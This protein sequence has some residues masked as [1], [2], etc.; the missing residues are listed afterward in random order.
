VECSSDLPSNLNKTSAEEGTMR[1]LW[2][3][4]KMGS[5]LRPLLIATFVLTFVHLDEWLWI[6]YSTQVF[7]NVG[8]SQNAAMRAS[9]FMSLPQAIVSVL[10]LFCF[11][12]FSRRCLLIVPT[13]VSIICAVLA[14]FGLLSN[15]GELFGTWQMHNVMPILASID[16]ASAAAASESAYTVVPELFSQRDRILGS[17]IVGIA[18]NTFGGIVA[19]ISLSVVNIHGTHFVLL[20]FIVM[21]VIYVFVVYAYL[22]ETNGYSFKSI[23]QN[24]SDDIPS[25]LHHFHFPSFRYILK[26]LWHIPLPVPYRG[27]GVTKVLFICLQVIVFLLVLYCALRVYYFL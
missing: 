12:G 22:P 5:F 23:S 24:F 20:P 15:T 9:L 2:Y 21:N 13:V 7:E 25:F 18:Q 14:V 11:D 8:L 19:T 10:L 3:R 27:R 1:Y 4:L 6:S 17:A 26:N 16:L